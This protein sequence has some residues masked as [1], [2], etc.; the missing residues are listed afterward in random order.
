MDGLQTKSEA[1]TEAHRGRLAPFAFRAILALTL[2]AFAALPLK[3]GETPRQKIPLKVF[4]TSSPRDPSP[5]AQADIAVTT[6]FLKMHPEIEFETFTGIQIAG[7]AMDSSMLLAIAGGN[8]PDVMYVNFRQSDTFI[9]QSFLLPLDKFIARDMSKAE[10]TTRVPP[11]VLPVVKREGPAVRGAEAGEH[12]WALPY[13]L[14]VRALFYRK[15]LFEEAGLDPKRP[16]RNWEELY[17]CSRRLSDPSKGLYGLQVTRGDHAAW[18]FMPFLWSAGGEAVTKDSKG[19]WKAVFDS[20]EAVTALDF[21]LKLTTEKWIDADGRR[22]IGYTSIASG[23]DGGLAWNEGRVGMAINY[24]DEKSIAAGVDP[25]LVDIAPFPAGPT[26][27]SGTEVNCS[28]MGIFSDIKGRRNSEGEYISPDKIQE[29]AWSYI[30]FFDSDAGRKIKIGKLVELGLG[31]RLNPDL[32]RKYGFNSYA[33]DVP[34]NWMPVFQEAMRNGRPEP[35]GKNCQEV[36]S[37]MTKPLEKAKELGRAGKLPTDPAE[38]QAVLK[39]LLEGAVDLTNSKMLDNLPPRE[40]RTRDIAAGVCASLLL[41]AFCLA[42]YKVWKAFA[43]VRATAST[44]S[45][46]LRK[47]LPAYIILAP[48]VISVLLW[49]YLPMLMGSTL[50]FCDYKFVASPEYVGL[51]NIGEILFSPDW[52]NALYCT[53]KYMA[54]LLILGFA[55]PIALA[56]MLQE[57]SKGRLLYRVVYYLPAVMSGMA[58]IYM[59]RLFFGSDSAGLINQMLIWTNELFG[60]S[61]EPI[62]WLENSNLAMLCCVIPTIWAGLGPGCLIYMAA[63]KGI[64]DELYESAEMDGASFAQKIVHIVL[65]SMRTLIVIQFIGAF[66]A[67][68][69]NTQMILVMTYGSAGTEVAGLHIFK[70]AYTL[71]KF[72]TAVSMAWMLGSVLLFFTIHQLRALQRLEFRTGG[73]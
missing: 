50:A 35:Y 38:R 61:M 43:S 72:G 45:G 2:A 70:E 6:A 11:A 47:Y 23:L 71:L 37:Y 3:A 20:D 4:S 21:Y 52:W 40:V 1:K 22:Q 67:A 32:L 30:R 63:L 9:Q 54:L 27:T 68:S 24:L 56:I 51:R 12:V 46:H 34:S 53:F 44:P 73:A 55:P 49:N 42:L 66:V 16:P 15:D 17:E 59:W 26:G 33:K 48:A 25:S 31:R 28:M 64:P 65:P 36:Y 18:D 19:Q 7:K 69:Q 14:V 41:A 57:V 5:I 10:F 58:V 60:E 8:A 39:K 62:A 13:N 29:A